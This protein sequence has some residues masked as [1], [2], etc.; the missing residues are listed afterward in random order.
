M[1]NIERVLNVAANDV[2][3]QFP[4][5]NRGVSIAGQGIDAANDQ[6]T[7]AKGFLT[8][9]Q[10]RVGDYQDAAGRAQNANNDVNQDLRQQSGTS[11]Q[12]AHSKQRDEGHSYQTG[13]KTQSL[14]T[15][16]NKDNNQSNE[17]VSSNDVKSMNTALTESLLSLSNL[18]DVQAK[19]SQKIWMH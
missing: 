7:D 12:S 13:I 2:P 11:Q 16:G 9:V 6:L 14:S 5:I 1:P 17:L 10:N 3:A 4:K 18:S 15:S 19:A 8:Q